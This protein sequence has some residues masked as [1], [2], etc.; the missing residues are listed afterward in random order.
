MRQ[1]GLEDEISEIGRGDIP[2]S[3]G[4]LSGSHSILMGDISGAFMSDLN[5]HFLSKQGGPQQRY[6]MVKR[7]SSSKKK[8]K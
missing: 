1:R 7:P 8:G 2:T 5:R 6:E 4:I 3:S